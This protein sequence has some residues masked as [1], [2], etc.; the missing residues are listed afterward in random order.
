LI[1]DLQGN[2]KEKFVRVT[3]QGESV[4]PDDFDLSGVSFTVVDQ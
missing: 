2:V 1:K 4:L 3:S